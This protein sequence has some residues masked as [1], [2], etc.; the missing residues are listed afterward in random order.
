MAGDHDILA[1][2]MVEASQRSSEFHDGFVE[3]A[4]GA[5]LR[6][7][8][9]GAGATNDRDDLRSVEDQRLAGEAAAATLIDVAH[10]TGVHCRLAHLLIRGLPILTPAEAEGFADVVARTAAR[11][12]YDAW[13]NLTHSRMEERAAKPRK[14]SAV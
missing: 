6:A 2:A 10:R 5:A 4:S 7:A 9:A 11:L 1:A 14:L 12:A 8:Q 13:T 3:I